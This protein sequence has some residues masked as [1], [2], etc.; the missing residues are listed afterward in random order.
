M[1]RLRAPSDTR[2]SKTVARVGLGARTLSKSRLPWQRS[3]GTKNFTKSNNINDVANTR[4]IHQRAL[5]MQ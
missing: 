1:I 4:D 3:F 5:E 2:R